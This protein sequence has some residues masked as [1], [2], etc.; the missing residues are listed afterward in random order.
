[1]SKITSTTNAWHIAVCRPEPQGKQL[2]SALVDAGHQAITQAF[3]AIKARATAKEIKQLLQEKQPDIIIFVSTAAVNCAQQALAIKQWRDFVASE[4]T[5]IAVGNTTKTVLRQYGI[6]PVV[7]PQQEN[8]EG[9][10]NLA[11]LQQ[12]QQKNIIIVRGDNGRELL[13]TKLTARGAQVSYLASYQKIWLMFEPTNIEE[14]W[15]KNKINCIVITSVA[16]LENLVRLLAATHSKN[17]WLKHCT[18]LVASPR[19]AKQAKM[20]NIN[21]IIIANGANTQAIIDTISTMD[22]T[23]D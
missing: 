2:A 4:I 1:M 18:W 12:V 9:M 7:T 20:H 21:K 10:L 14:R 19:I 5:F 6:T 3:F 15:Q 8:S 11:K 13:A 17:Y 22:L 23:N 16:L